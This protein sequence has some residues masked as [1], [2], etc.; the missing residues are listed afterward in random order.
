MVVHFYQMVSQVKLLQLLRIHKR[1]RNRYQAIA[2]VMAVSNQSH[3]RPFNNLPFADAGGKGVKAGIFLR[4]VPVI[5]LPAK[6]GS[7]QK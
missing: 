2:P 6:S 5:I 4:S 7:K 1:Y 3:P